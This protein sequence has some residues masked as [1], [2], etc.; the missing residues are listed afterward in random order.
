MS[1]HETRL[2]VRIEELWNSATGG[3]LSETFD[4][5]DALLAEHRAEVARLERERDEAMRRHG[6]AVLS[7]SAQLNAARDAALEEAADV[8]DKRA[9]AARRCANAATGEK[10]RLEWSEAA[11]VSESDAR[12]IRALK[13]K[14]AEPA[15][16]KP[17]GGESDPRCMCGNKRSEHNE[18]GLRRKT[19]SG[20]RLVVCEGFESDGGT[21]RT[22]EPCECGGESSRHL[23]CGG[24]GYVPSGGEST[25]CPGCGGPR[26]QGLWGMSCPRC[27]QGARW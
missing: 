1:E 26:L 12:T 14:P 9:E 8:F 17:S 19:Y 24:T 21:G 4:M 15:R 10:V 22:L 23:K 27:A 25:A 7:G 3:S 11:E 16:E 13:S 20:R 2:R 18:D 6:A 5:L